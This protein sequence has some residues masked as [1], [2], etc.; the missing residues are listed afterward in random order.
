MTADIVLYPLPHTCMHTHLH[1]Q[2]CTYK[3]IRKRCSDGIRSPRR[4]L[5][6]KPVFT[7]SP[8]GKRSKNRNL[9]LAEEELG[10]VRETMERACSPGLHLVW[11]KGLCR[12]SYSRFVDTEFR[13]RDS[14]T[15]AL[16]QS[17]KCVRAS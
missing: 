17:L 10:V 9:T 1:T 7:L 2:T 5:R 14:L 16:G 15:L 12:T 13:E 6:E 8:C 3:Q 4:P 11:R